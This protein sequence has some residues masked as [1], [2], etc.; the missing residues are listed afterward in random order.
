VVVTNYLWS[1]WS[2]ALRRISNCICPGCRGG[3]FLTALAQGVRDGD[4]LSSEGGDDDLVR[5][6]SLAEAICE[7]F[8]DGVVMCRN[9]CRSEH[10]VPQGTATSSYR[11]FP[12]KGSTIVRDRACGAGFG[13]ASRG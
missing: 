9:Q 12:A 3:P 1:A 10:H 11:S 13:D 6:S 7:G 8:H 2:V 4:E 5:F